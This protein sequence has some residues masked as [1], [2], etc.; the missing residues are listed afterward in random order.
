MLKKTAS[1]YLIALAC[2]CGFLS[3]SRAAAA[4]IDPPQGSPSSTQ[5]PSTSAGTPDP[6]RSISN[7]SAFVNEFTGQAAFNIPLGAISN[8]GDISYSLNLSYY[9]GGLEHNSPRRF[10]FNPTSWVG[11]GFSLKAPYILADPKGTVDVNDDTYELSMDGNTQMDLI[12]EIDNTSSLY[13]KIRPYQHVIRGTGSLYAPW[14]VEMPDGTRYHFGSAANDSSCD[15]A[16]SVLCLPIQGPV[17]H[18]V[19]R[20]K[21]APVLWYLTSISSRDS[22]FRIFFKYQKET[23]DGADRA[24]Y[25][26]R[27]YAVNGNDTSSAVVSEVLFQTQGKGDYFDNSFRDPLAHFET[28]RL[29][30]VKLRNQGQTIREFHFQYKSGGG[31]TRLAEIKETIGSQERKYYRCEYDTTNP[32]QIQKVFGPT[33]IA[34]EYGYTLSPVNSI[35]QV[36]D[37]TPLPPAW[38]WQIGFT[39]EFN[40][41]YFVLLSTV[42]NISGGTFPGRLYEFDHRGTY[43]KLTRTYTI[44][45][46]GENAFAMAPDGS[47]FA[48][49]IGGSVAGNDPYNLRI[50]NTL[51]SSIDSI[52]EI[53]LGGSPSSFPAGFLVSNN[54]NLRLKRIAALN[55]EGGV[56]LVGPQ[57]SAFNDWLTMYRPGYGTVLFFQRSG[58][59]WSAT[60]PDYGSAANPD[61]WVLNSESAPA[62]LGF[63][64]NPPTAVDPC[65][66]WDAIRTTSGFPVH[67]KRFLEVRPGEN[68]VALILSNTG[69]TTDYPQQWTTGGAIRIFARIAG[70]IRWVDTTNR[71]PKINIL[72]PS[73]SRAVTTWGSDVGRAGTQNDL[74]LDVSVQ[75]DLVGVLVRWPSGSNILNKYLQVFSVNLEK[76]HLDSVYTADFGSTQKI[77]YPSEPPLISTN[78]AHLFIGRNFL[79]YKRRHVAISPEQSPSRNFD[80]DVYHFNRATGQTEKFPG[81]DFSAKFNTA[82]KI[83]GDHFFV[84]TVNWASLDDSIPEI[85]QAYR[86]VVSGETYPVVGPGKLCRIVPRKGT[87][88]PSLQFIP[89]PGLNQLTL[90]GDRYLAYDNSAGKKIY[91][92]GRINEAGAP[93]RTEISASPDSM[94]GVL[95]PTGVL[96]F[97]KLTTVPKLQFYDDFKGSLSPDSISAI[98]QVK[99][100]TKGDSSS[101]ADGTAQTFQIDYSEGV[102]QYHAKGKIPNFKKVK[103]ILAGPSSQVLTEFASDFQGAELAGARQN[104]HGIL[105]KTTIRPGPAAGRQPG[106]R[107]TQNDYAVTELGTA[108]DT[109]NS[110]PT[111]RQKLQAARLIQSTDKTFFFRSLRSMRKRYA[112]F[113]G[114]NGLPRTAITTRGGDHQMEVTVFDDTASASKVLVKQTASY[115]FTDLTSDPCTGPS[116]DEC[117]NL[118]GAWFLAADSRKKKATSSQAFKYTAQGE[119]NETYS[120][121]PKQLGVTGL[122]TLD[123]SVTIPA[124]GTEQTSGK[125]VKESEVLSRAKDQAMALSKHNGP[126]ITDRRG[127][128]ATTFYGGLE[129]LPLAIAENAG[130]AVCSFLGAEEET[131]GAGLGAYGDW[132][133]V[134]T[135]STSIAHS[136][137]KSI[138]ST[139]A[140]G[141]SI[142]IHFKQDAEYW[143]RGKGLVVS[144]WMFVPGVKGGSSSNDPM[145][146]ALIELR[147][148]T[149]A[150]PSRIISL[151]PE[152]ENSNGPFPYNRWVKLEAAV[153]WKDLDSV[154]GT[155]PVMRVW[156]GKQEILPPA[157]QNTLPVFVDDLRIHPS[158]ATLTSRN[159][160]ARDRVTSILDASNF[161]VFPQYDAWDQKIG[162]KDDKGRLFSASAFKRAGED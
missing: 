11:E 137:R 4:R 2:L 35:P 101:A 105:V 20:P 86:Q 160:D 3:D 134:G 128:K 9:G 49:A 80:I 84:E 100:S 81:N 99:I 56:P 104:L 70:Q 61:P 41:K 50:F 139:G 75:G 112:D 102:P 82:I 22:A 145:P 17:F 71:V 59:T 114:R 116:G 133:P 15:A 43:W 67:D 25:L 42:P 91:V 135:L 138:R 52:G 58:N 76:N 55:V 156:F 73:T 40:G 98:S 7:T 159:Y 148:S 97:N 32:W 16:K 24:I 90:A 27:I 113:D 48:V 120:W 117:S 95:S 77:F 30:A 14:V 158:D 111:L 54:E 63:K 44:P 21:K 96:E 5:V 46:G 144:G 79:V 62:G 53:D 87:T 36:F 85:Y 51:A 131:T 19:P 142:N 37:M 124:G 151:I 130:K 103:R 109:T 34:W 23:V 13:P 78:D 129:G 140:F 152:Y 154:G 65:L 162:V 121:R 94:M 93:T 69:G 141:P 127:V 89:V 115:L 83:M 47:Y 132:E 74:L 136:G 66:T 153:T 122:Q 26:E 31:K 28:Q 118:N 33:G 161:P 108:P 123:G 72:N 38:K 143:A 45:I 8:H 107:E 6:L 146:A 39:G 64:L 147:S 18:S 60:C 155:D 119:L 125:W 126:A 150:A 29:A 149:S 110:G 92:Y 106:E 68:F 1:G 88:P 10:E 157:P 57:I 12:P